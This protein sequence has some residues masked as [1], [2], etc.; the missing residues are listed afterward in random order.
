MSKDRQGWEKAETFFGDC[1]VHFNVST[2]EISIWCNDFTEW[3]SELFRC[4]Y[5]EMERKG[6]Y[7]G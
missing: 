4:L 7:D 6:M 2:G 1:E 3:N 5:L